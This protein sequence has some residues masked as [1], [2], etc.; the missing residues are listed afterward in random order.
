MELIR[1]L[2]DVFLNEQELLAAGGIDRS[3]LDAMQKRGVMPLPSYTL[4]LDI[5]C[6]SFFGFHQA[7]S[8]LAY[9]AKAY[10]AWI[11]TVRTMQADEAFDL[12][13]RRY[14]SQLQLLKG[15]GISTTHEKLNTGLDAHLRNE[16]QH[17]L[18]GTYG[19]CTKSGL[20]ED[21]AIKE[22]AVIV[23]K[24]MTGE[25]YDTRLT[26][27]ERAKLAE[28]VNLLDSASAP[29]APHELARSSRHRLIDR[30]R[31][32]YGI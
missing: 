27:T 17:F 5:S 15:A 3:E 11:G 20:P 18:N 28:A 2:N 7:Q 6:N 32:T 12:F 31:T 26:P 23:I 22:L 24:D 16:W 19:L 14:V 30:M 29:F 8:D 1:Y 13:S 21:I 25:R 4:K 9:Y 10:P